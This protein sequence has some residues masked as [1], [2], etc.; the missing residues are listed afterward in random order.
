MILELFSQFQFVDP[1]ILRSVRTYLPLFATIDFCFGFTGF[2]RIGVDEYFDPVFFL[3]SEYPLGLVPG[4]LILIEYNFLDFKQFP[5]LLVL[6]ENVIAALC[7]RNQHL[8]DWQ[9]EIWLFFF[10]FGSQFVDDGIVFSLIGSKR[11]T[12]HMGIGLRMLAQWFG[13]FLLH[14]LY[15]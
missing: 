6:I 2:G 8:R 4:P 13:R 9:V 12:L 5:V 14:C 11:C 3:H 10:F 7:L 15:Y 1:F